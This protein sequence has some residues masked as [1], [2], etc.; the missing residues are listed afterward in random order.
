MTVP[1]DTARMTKADR[2]ALLSLVKKRER[3]MKAQAQERSAAMLADFDAQ[4]TKLWSWDE[5]AVWSE[6]KTAA[7]AAFDEANSR[8]AARCKELGIPDEFAPRL[9]FQWNPRYENS[10]D[11]RR[12]E[13][14]RTA[15]SRIEAIE[16]DAAAKIERSSLEAQTQLLSHGLGGEAAQKFLE[17]LESIDRLMPA[18][19]ITEVQQLVEAR[20]KDPVRYLQ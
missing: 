8:I 17:G 20:R 15:R 2:D 1:D 16:K 7:E 13:L 4:M 19:D 14:R 12:A 9:T 5:D 18:L 6:A 10:V 3:V 11:S